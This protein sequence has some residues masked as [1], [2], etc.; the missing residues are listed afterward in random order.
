M[1]DDFIKDNF[2]YL[3]FEDDSIWDEIMTNIQ[4]L[5]GRPLAKKCMN[6]FGRQLCICEFMDWLNGKKIGGNTKHICYSP[7]HHPH[8]SNYISKKEK[9][10]LK[11]YEMPDKRPLWLPLYFWNWML[12]FKAH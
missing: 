3:N 2:G 1:G 9:K 7:N 4:T 11:D 10:R 6:I 12:F 8:Y 5:R